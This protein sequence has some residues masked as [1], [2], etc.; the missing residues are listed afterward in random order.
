MCD[1]S[2]DVMCLG[3]LIEKK[4]HELSQAVGEPDRLKAT[5]E[6]LRIQAIDLERGN[7]AKT[8]DIA[9][10]TTQ[11]S[12]QSQRQRLTACVVLCC[13]VLCCNLP[14]R[15]D[16][17]EEQEQRAIAAAREA[18]TALEYE[19]DRIKEQIKTEADRV[20][21]VQHELDFERAQF[22]EDCIE[23][24]KAEERMNELKAEE[25]AQSERLKE[26]Q[27]EH[28]DVKKDYESAARI[29]LTYQSQIPSLEREVESKRRDLEEKRAQLRLQKA[30][31]DEIHQDIELFYSQC[32]AQE[33]IDADTKRQL[34]GVMNDKQTAQC[35]DRSLARI[36]R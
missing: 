22:E 3:S 2:R 24:Q 30:M 7:E 18:W 17:R 5:I 25:K 33:K 10:Y 9:K 36:T 27:K 34:D 11:H 26:R 19:S 29:I 6:S 13:V 4:K 14:R 20:R 1:H 23:L 35:I 21:E 15:L 31:A 16:E 32:L 8:A 12:S 28:R